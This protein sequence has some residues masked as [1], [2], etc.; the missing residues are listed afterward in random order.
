VTTS[1]H[2]EVKTC[3]KKLTPDEEPCSGAK[4]LAW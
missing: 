4:T 3:D 1:F 2:D